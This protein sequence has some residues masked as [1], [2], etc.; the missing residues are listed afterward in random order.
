MDTAEA[1]QL[2][3]FQQHSFEDLRQECFVKFKWLRFIV[4]P[5]GFLVARLALLFLK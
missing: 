5:F 2:L 3:S 4:R 1:E